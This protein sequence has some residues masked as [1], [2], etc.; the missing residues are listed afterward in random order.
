MVKNT[1]AMQARQITSKEDLLNLLNR[2]KMDEMAESGMADSFCPFTMK[3]INYYCNPNNV[4]HRY[5]QFCIKKKSGGTRQITAPRNK[6]FRL[7][8]QYV[9]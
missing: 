8:L 4:F 7:M 5:K 9:N 3:H 1:I 2:M 6:S